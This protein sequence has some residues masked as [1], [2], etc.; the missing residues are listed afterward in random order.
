MSSASC[1]SDH[2]ATCRCRTSGRDVGVVGRDLPPALRPVFRG[3]PHEADEP[4][5]E[6]LDA[7][8]LHAAL[9][10]NKVVARITSEMGR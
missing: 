4:V 9:C 6:R 2:G 3:H 8:D 10:A 5:A 7:L 1:P